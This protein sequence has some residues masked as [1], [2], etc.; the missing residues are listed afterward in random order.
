MQEVFKVTGKE[1][2]LKYKDGKGI[3]QTESTKPKS[4]IDSLGIDINIIE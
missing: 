4:P 3:N 1:I 2:H